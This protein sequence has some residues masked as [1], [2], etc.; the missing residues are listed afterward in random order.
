MRIR[1]R[2][3]PAFV[4]TLALLTLGPLTEAEAHYC[5]MSCDGGRM[6]CVA[7]A[8]NVYQGCRYQCQATFP[9]DPAGRKTCVESCRVTRSGDRAVCESNS[10]DCRAL[11]LTAADKKCADEEC[12]LVYGL[13]KETV[14]KATRACVRAAGKN[15][16]AIQACVEPGDVMLDLGRAALDQCLSDP[17]GFSMCLAGC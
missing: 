6:A 11:C 13:C 10:D 3:V 5:S 14:R 7:M 15:G 8:G 4:L 16:P 17:T 2:L 9:G 1:F 12:S